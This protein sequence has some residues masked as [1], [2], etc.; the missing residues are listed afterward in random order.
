[1][2]DNAIYQGSILLVEDGDSQSRLIINCLS[3]N[4]Y[5][6]K[7]CANGQEAFKLLG[8]SETEKMSNAYLPDLMIVD[9]GL[10]DMNGF[11]FVKNILKKDSKF[12]DVPFIFISGQF[13]DKDYILEGLNIGAYDYLRK[14]FDLDV[15]LLKVKNCVDFYRSSKDDAKLD[16]SHEIYDIKETA[17]YLRV[18]EKTIYNLVNKGK[19]P[20]LKIGGQW[21]FSKEMLKK[22]FL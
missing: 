13:V 19:I 17:E 7:R 6:V 2:I 12:F 5:T 11:E 10:P 3:E 8:I 21:R 14:P 1:M 22:M 4:G 16:L 18:T 20:A 15:L 9:I